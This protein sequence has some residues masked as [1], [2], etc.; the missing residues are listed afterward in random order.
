MQLVRGLDVRHFLEHIHQFRKV[1]ELGESGSGTVSGSFRSQLN[2]CRC[3]TKGGCPGIEVGQVF[4]LERSILEIAHDRV[5][6]GHGVADRSAGGEDNA[7][8][9]SDLVH[10]AAFHKHIRGFLCF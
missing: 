9:A 10:I 1:E 3:L 8:T 6:L 2:G 5:K 4:L 7:T